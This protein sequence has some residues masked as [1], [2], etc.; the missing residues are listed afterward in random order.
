MRFSIA[1]MIEQ[2]VH[3]ILQLLCTG[4]GALM[5]TDSL[6][7]MHVRF[8][9]T[10]Y[11]GIR[12]T[13]SVVSVLCIECYFLVNLC[14]TSP[15]VQPYAL[16]FRVATLDCRAETESSPL[17]ASRAARLI[18]RQCTRLSRLLLAKVVR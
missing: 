2:N 11:V 1:E 16:E 13:C 8:T 10:S 17:T 4:V 12:S 3:T 14:N 7:N 9:K 15:N 6:N 18:H 5:L